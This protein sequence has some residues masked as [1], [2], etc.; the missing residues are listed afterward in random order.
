MHSITPGVRSETNSP[1]WTIHD[2][3]ELSDMLTT[4]PYP[5]FTPYAGIDPIN[6]MKNAFH[7]TAQSRYYADI[8][9]KPCIAEELGTLCAMVAGEEVKASYI[10][11]TMFNL[12]S[13]NCHGLIWWCGFD[14]LSLEHTPYDWTAI[15]RELGLFKENH[16]PKPVVAEMRRFK[17]FIALLPFEN[18][19]EFKREAICILSREQDTWANAWGSFLLAK[20]AGFDVEFQYSADELKESDLYIVPGLGGSMSF[21]RHEW[22]ELIGKVKA[23]ATLYL[24]LDDGLL[25]PFNQVFGVEA[26]YQQHI[27][28]TVKFSLTDSE[29]A[30]D[31]SCYNTLKPT[32][33]EVLIADTEGNPLFTSS[34]LGKGTVY[35]LNVPVEHHLCQTP[36]SFHGDTANPH[37]ELYKLFAGP[38]LDK[39]LVKS[40]NPSVTITEHE[41][42]S[43]ETVVIVVNNQPEAAN[44]LLE[45]K[46]EVTTMLYGDSLETI[47]ANDAL[48]FILK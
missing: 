44:S 1:V 48:V 12:W 28:K 32:R 4:H 13:H 16:E 34:K 46:G 15:E 40:D 26:Q 19:P 10:R 5:K 22:L 31:T 37:F 6:R 38:W 43:G 45:I 25:A 42:D 14:Q 24:S 33:A 35:L 27:T 18:L 29:M 20:Q 30:V 23:G 9:G 41:L 2:Q 47:N 17:E 36:G 3:G 39:R 11:N 8:G 21:H 7:A